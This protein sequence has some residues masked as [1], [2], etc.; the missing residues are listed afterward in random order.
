MAQKERLT[1][2]AQSVIAA[3]G[4]AVAALLWSGVGF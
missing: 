2:V 4:L 3:V 1:F